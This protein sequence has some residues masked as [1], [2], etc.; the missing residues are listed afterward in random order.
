LDA[1][2]KASQRGSVQW[3][4]FTFTYRN[5]INQEQL[6]YWT[7]GLWWLMVE[8]VAEKYPRGFM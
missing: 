1:F 5:I 4:G 2:L 3:I 8:A 6:Y 7:A